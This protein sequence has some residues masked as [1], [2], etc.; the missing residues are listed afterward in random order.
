MSEIRVL[1]VEDDRSARELLVT[2]LEDDGYKVFAVADGI[3]ALRAA[4][5]FHPNLAL[6]DAGLPGLDGVDVARR[7]RQLSDV[8]IVFVTGADSAAA[9]H[10]G[11]RMGADDYIV[12]PYD[13]EELSWRVRAV[14]RRSGHSV[15][16]VWEC[17]DL[18]FDEGAQ[19]V[20]RAGS[21]IEL[22]ATEF[23]LLGLLIR[24]RS[25]VVAKGQL[26][27]DVWGYDADGHLLEVHMSSLRRK[28]EAKG[29]RLIQTVRGTGYVLRP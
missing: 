8:P 7:L 25:R 26:L 3:A 14:L 6:L 24:S 21:S 9:I 11:F 19:Q 15:A 28:L 12:K 27:G 1:V 4:E 10:G 16:D 18:V 20:T 5:T 22:T 17:G 29:P 23:K 2:I 13:A